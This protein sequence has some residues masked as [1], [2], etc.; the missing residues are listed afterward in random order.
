MGMTYDELGVY[1]RLR[2][3]ARL[4]PVEMFKRL[5]HEW[6][7]RGTP[8]EIAVKVKRFFFFYSA[9]R[10]KMTTLTPSYHAENYSP[11]D[12][13]F[14]LRPFLYNVR[15]PWQFRKIDELVEKAMKER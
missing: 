9:N 4:G 2:K 10:H 5:L 8:A 7:D 15:W 3:I 12:N 13:R 14:D 6:K 11:E 1:G